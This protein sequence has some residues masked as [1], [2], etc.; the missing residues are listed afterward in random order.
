[1]TRRRYGGIGTLPLP[2]EIAEGDART[3]KR[4]LDSFF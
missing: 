4:Q 1:L 2:P 3:I